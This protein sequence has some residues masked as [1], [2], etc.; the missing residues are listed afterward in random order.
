MSPASTGH[1]FP[2]PG[3]KTIADTD[4]HQII[5]LPPKIVARNCLVPLRFRGARN[6]WFIISLFIRGII[7]YY[8]VKPQ[9]T[10]LYESGDYVTSLITLNYGLY[11]I[12]YK[13]PLHHMESASKAV[14]ILFLILFLL[15]FSFMKLTLF[16]SIGL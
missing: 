6:T 11:S 10:F 1:A 16:K 9:I 2:S 13:C 14:V 15:S 8:Y 3:L 12:N 5:G 4:N 7:T